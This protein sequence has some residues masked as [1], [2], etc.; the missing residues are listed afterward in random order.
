MFDSDLY[1]TF[2]RRN[3]T[4]ATEEDAAVAYLT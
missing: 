4:V 2:T 1:E 3:N